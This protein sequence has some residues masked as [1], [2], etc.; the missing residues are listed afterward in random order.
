MEFWQHGA[1]R[2]HDR[3]EYVRTGDRWAR[4]LLNP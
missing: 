1:H 4:H 3:V 2:L